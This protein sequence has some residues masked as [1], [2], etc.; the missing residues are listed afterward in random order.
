MEIKKSLLYKNLHLL[1]T[2]QL[3]E[4]YMNQGYNVEL[5]KRLGN[6]IADLL[7]TKGEEKIVIEV[8]SGKMDTASKKKLASMADYVSS[9]GGYKFKVVLARPPENKKIEIENL[10]NL[11]FEYF[12]HDIPSELDELS[13]HTS[14]EEVFDLTI[15]SLHV[16]TKG[17]ITIQGY[18]AIEVQLQYGSNKDQ[19]SGDGHITSTS[20]PMTFDIVIILSNGK[21]HIDEGDINIDTSSFY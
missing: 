11:F 18:G 15:N 16:N 14:I 13:T 4:D 17:E 21:M 3:A 2:Q 12:L 1:A 7:I 5:E 20:F 6:F 8:K 19:D 9:L 10:E